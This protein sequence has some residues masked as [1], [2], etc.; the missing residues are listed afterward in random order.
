MTHSETGLRWDVEGVGTPRSD[1]GPRPAFRVGDGAGPRSP[2]GRGPHRTP[3]YF[4]PLPEAVR[5]G[6]GHTAPKALA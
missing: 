1:R 5:T 4:W 3:G 2:A 6:T